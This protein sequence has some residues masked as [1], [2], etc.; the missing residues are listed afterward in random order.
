[1]ADTWTVTD[2][3]VGRLLGVVAVALELP[4]ALQVFVVHDDLFDLGWLFLFALWGASLALAAFALSAGQR[5]RIGISLAC[6]GLGGGLVPVLVVWA[7]LAAFE[8]G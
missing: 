6:F 5:D 1:M 2:R 7:V 3:R 4:L 8:Q